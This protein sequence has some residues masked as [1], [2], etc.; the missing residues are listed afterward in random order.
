MNSK[1]VLLIILIFSVY[2]FASGLRAA[3]E[4]G[5]PTYNVSGRVTDNYGFK[6]VNVL[7]KA[8]NEN[9]AIG[10]KTTATDGEG[11]Y[12]VTGLPSSNYSFSYTK[13]G[14][15]TGLLDVTISGSDITNPDIKLS[16]IAP[17][18]INSVILNTTTPNTGNSVHVTVNAT[19]NVA[20]TSVKANDVS[21]MQSSDIWSGDLTAIEGTHSVNVYASDAAGNIVWDNSTSYTATTPDT[22]APTITI[23][24][25]ANGQTFKT[26]SITVSGTASDNIGLSKVEVKVGTGGWQSVSGT[27][28]WNAIVTLSEGSNTI[29]AQATDTS[30]NTQQTSITVN[31]DTIPPDS[32]SNPS[33]TTGNFFINNS[34]VNPPNADFSYVW[35]KYS[36]G[37]N[38]DNVSAPRDYYYHTWTPHYTQN[39]SAQ[40]VDTQGNVN[41]TKVWF[42]AT[43][44]NNIPSIPVKIAPINRENFTDGSITITWSA[45]KDVDNDKL[46]YDWELSNRSDFSVILKSENTASLSS[47]VSLS[48]GTY[49][50]RVRAN[51]SFDKSA[52]NQSSTPDFQVVSAP[53]I[54]NVRALIEDNSTIKVSW[55][56]NQNDSLNRVLYGYTPDLKDGTWSSWNN[57]TDNPNIIIGGLKG[58]SIYYQAF[59]YNAGN[60]SAYSNSSIFNLVYPLQVT[61]YYIEPVIINDNETWRPTDTGHVGKFIGVDGYFKN[62][63]NDSLTLTIL[64]NNLCSEPCTVAL[65]KNDNKSFMKS[66]GWS[67][68]EINSSDINGEFLNSTL[69]IKVMGQNGSWAFNYTNTTTISLKI[70]PIFKIKRVFRSSD[71]MEMGLGSIVAVS[72]GSTTTIRYM[73]EANSS[74]NLT[75]VQICDLYY[76]KNQGGPCFNVPKKLEA[77][78]P[79]STNYTY[80]AT[81]KDLSSMKCEESVHLGV[82]CIIN[83]V[84]FGAD[85]ES[86]GSHIKDTEYVRLL[87]GTPVNTEGSG[88]G[89][90]GSSGGGGGGG[91]MAPSEDIKNIERREIREM[92]ILSRTA[93]TYI[94]RSADPVMVVTFE[95][96]VSENE[97]PVAVEV[98]KNRSKNIK[99]DAPGK[100]YKYFN[101]FVGTSGFSKK[102]SNG[103]IAYRVNNSWLK[104]NGLN[105]EDISLYK[106]R[107]TWVKLDTEIAD[108]NSNSTY[109]ASLV[110]NF[111]SFAI[112]GI[113]EQ[114][115]GGAYMPDI[116]ASSEGQPGN[117]TRVSANLSGDEPKHKIPGLSAAVIILVF[118]TAGIIF[119]L[120][121]NHNKLNKEGVRK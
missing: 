121:R 68:F 110:G 73:L 78:I 109:Y 92:D 8:S 90:S 31:L 2:F 72:E 97:V 34:W 26:P 81:T 24:F 28:T 59:S 96:S 70:I 43:I 52:W 25:P 98:L 12:L 83:Q 10:E 103:V 79:N 16:D 111:S 85:V 75:N 37:T 40:T 38:L 80:R 76:P 53:N 64:N 87:V 36:D 66:L 104:E 95:S 63:G 19:D 105:P 41:P 108:N 69:Q 107:D 61:L 101:V 71:N 22:T 106:W 113:K 29:Y 44:P 57:S 56:T 7:V 94:F 46:T 115:I 60:S 74:V 89:S 117:I 42:N 39:I 88:G 118:A 86:T 45:S 3:S 20:V 11:N 58:Q 77:N 102:V 55:A 21:L 27:T 120:K 6:L 15:S 1:K 14:F 49:Y 5:E 100:P 62:L 99:D 35:L 114:K 48:V 9:A 4:G 67:A 50:W 119:Y 93:S 32:V 17:P 33:T 51:D 18:T 23:T 82:P 84:T 91:G 13:E 116:P 54:D 47:D 30:G 65:A 112:V